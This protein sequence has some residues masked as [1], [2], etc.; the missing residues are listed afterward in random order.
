MAIEGRL[1]NDVHLRAHQRDA[2]GLRHVL[3]IN[4]RAL[5]LRLAAERRVSDA[6]TRDSRL[7]LAQLLEH[8][9][10]VRSNVSSRVHR[11][12]DE[13]RGRDRGGAAQHSR[14]ILFVF[15]LL[16]FERRG[17][18][19]RPRSGDLVE[20]RDDSIADVVV[21]TEGVPDHPPVRNMMLGGRRARLIKALHVMFQQRLISDDVNLVSEGGADHAGD[22]VDNAVV[23]PDA[24]VVAEL[25]AQEMVTLGVTDA[26]ARLVSLRW[27]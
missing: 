4:G 3:P 22:D 2:D 14:G 6:V 12:S 5:R 23:P 16:N 11:E 13:L 20:A 1:Q 26:S 18:G 17:T 10:A 19:D 21:V 27:V 8:G 15:I 9:V 25:A 24:A 7:A